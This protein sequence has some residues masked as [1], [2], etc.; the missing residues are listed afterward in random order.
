VAHRFSTAALV[1]GALL[2]AGPAG[3]QTLPVADAG[4]DQEIPCAPATGAEVTLDG[5][6]SSD[7]DDPLAMLTYT[8][9]GDAALG[10]GVTLDGVAPVVPLPPG[11]HV[12]TLTVDD[13]V[14][15]PASDDVQITIVADTEPPQLV[16]ASSEAEL[17]PPNHKVHAFAAPDFVASV[18]DSCD[19]ELGPEGAVFTGGTSD[20]D[21]NGNGDGNTTG[22]LSFECGTA[23]VRSE[24][25]G[26]G[27]GRVYEL[28]LSVLDAAGN[29]S[30]PALVTVSVP[31]D[32]AHAA[33]DSGDVFEVIADACVP[34]ELCPAEPSETCDD[35]GEASASIKTRGKHGATL[36]WRAK[37]FAATEGE[38]SDPATD[39]QLC[40]YTDDGVTA[41]LEDDPAAPHGRGWKQKGPGAA[42]RGK[43]GGPHARLDGLKLKEK[44]G[45]G[46]LSLSV[47]GDGVALPELPLAQ[48]EALVLQLHDSDG[49]CLSSTF[50]DPEKNTADRFQDRTE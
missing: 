48:G 41:V 40:V 26:P 3:A 46:K 36:R 47:G 35:A 32:Q 30:E 31:H 16:L 19:T 22:D 25:A 27:D 44:K 11:V 21:D 2:L 24:R 14:D 50:D 45:Q 34:V 7:P 5:S 12:L 8:W 1:A 10:V 13:G 49:D 42:F 39:Y 33:V 23:L 17:W 6:G 29:A 38:F 43:Q 15:L 28:T 20:E 18:T 9:S 4:D 37:S